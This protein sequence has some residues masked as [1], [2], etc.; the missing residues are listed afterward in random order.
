MSDLCPGIYSAFTM[1]LT[2]PC[3]CCLGLKRAMD[4]NKVL[5][6]N[7][8][9]TET[10]K[11]LPLEWATF[12]EKKVGI[13]LD[14]TNYVPKVTGITDVCVPIMPNIGKKRS[15]RFGKWPRGKG[16]TP[17]RKAANGAVD[18]YEWCSRIGAFVHVTVFCPVYGKKKETPFSGAGDI[19]TEYFRYTVLLKPVTGVG[20]TVSPIPSMTNDW[21]KCVFSTGSVYNTETQC[22][23]GKPGGVPLDIGGWK[24]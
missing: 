6:L 11:T 1:A 3:S 19:W 24:S 15:T 21:T 8:F 12:L 20:G 18:T 22:G 5:T 23:V 16:C 17:K 10:R 9:S 7:F 4:R 2:C 14:Q 13:Q